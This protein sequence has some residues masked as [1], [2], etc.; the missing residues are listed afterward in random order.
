[1]II[2][3]TPFR[4]SLFGG[5]TD[6]P[7]W[8]LNDGGCVL[9]STINKYC[10]VLARNLPPFF[11]YQYRIRYYQNEEANTVDDIQHPVVRNCIKYVG[12]GAGFEIIHSAD[13]PARSGLGSSSSF[14]VGLLHALSGLNG[15]MSTKRELAEGAL[16]IE[17]EMNKE[18][19]GSQDQIAA[20][21]GGFNKISFHQNGSFDV[22][23]LMV[24]R[25]RLAALNDHF[26]LCFTGFS[27]TASE[28]AAE[29]VKNLSNSRDLLTEMMS[30]CT[31]AVDLLAGDSD[32]ERIGTL[33]HRQWVL[34]KGLSDV[35][36]NDDIDLIY[37]RALAAGA[38][39]GKLL[40]AG[41]GGFM[42]LMAPPSKHEAVKEALKGKLFVPFR[43]E[44]QGSSIIYFNR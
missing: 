5:G 22:S 11:E 1:M 28:V 32:M 38:I 7:S 9:S 33:L 23:P 34:K 44:E 24:N 17:Q 26:L 13:L 35:V 8:Y 40:G 30:I 2:S 3:R 37:N 18:C 31:E 21:F 43:F 41:S 29:K 27:R 16:Y 15:K 36:S 20:A 19:V 6:Y 42:L 25:D 39:G 14:T 4:V 10:F 12:T